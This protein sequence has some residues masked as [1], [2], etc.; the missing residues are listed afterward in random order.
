MDIKKIAAKMLRS[1]WQL[2]GGRTLTAFDRTFKFTADTEFPIRSSVKFP[3]EGPGSN[4][5]RYAD[6]VQFHAA[7][8]FLCDLNRA[9]TVVD[10]GAHH[11][12]YAIILGK[13]VQERRGHLIAVEPNPQSYAVLRENVRLNQ[14]EDTV[15]C[16]PM[17]IS[18]RQ[19]QRELFFDGSQTSLAGDRQG[20]VSVEVARL[21]DL[22]ARY[23]ILHVDLLQ[24]DVEGAELNVL[25]GFPWGHV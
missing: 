19:E 12:I 11:G 20:N 13:F 15:F 18:D 10:V 21:E 9:P 25:R 23:C 22:L 5:V 4:I 17:A 6:F 2:R 7:C 24:I 16:E 8:R 3:R 1:W 14:L